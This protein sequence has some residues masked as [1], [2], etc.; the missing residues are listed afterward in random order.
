MGYEAGPASSWCSARYPC[1]GPC[2]CHHTRLPWAA[3]PIARWVPQLGLPWPSS[4]PA[5][6]SFCRTILLRCGR[7]R[8]LPGPWLPWHCPGK[9]GRGKPLPYAHQSKKCGNFQGLFVSSPSRTALTRPPSTAGWIPQGG[10]RP[11][12]WRFFPRFLIGE[13]SGISGASP[14]GAAARARY[15]PSWAWSPVSGGVTGSLVGLASGTAVGWVSG[16]SVGAAVG[17]GGRF[18]GISITLTWK[19]KILGF[20]YC[21]R[22]RQRK[23]A[24]EVFLTKKTWPGRK[25]RPGH[26]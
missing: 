23:G 11:R 15:R 25:I 24:L 16:A 4:V 5:A 6:G 14:A 17:A 1:C 20:P 19:R 12:L 22:M 2:L 9:F 18:W 7:G 8:G 26:S 21:G 13:K 3:G 10:G